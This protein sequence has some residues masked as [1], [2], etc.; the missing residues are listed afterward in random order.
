MTSP[1]A[2]FDPNS[3]STADSGIF[4][5][6]FG[7][8]DA[9]LVVIPVPWEVTTSY[10]SGASL[11]PP[12]ILAASRQVDLFDLDLV[13]PYA[14]GI[15]LRD[16]RSE[17]A[18]WNDEGKALAQHV[19]NVAGHVEGAPELEHAVTRVNELGDAL[20]LLVAE[21]TRSVL[22]AGKIP[23]VLGGDHSV[24]FGAISALAERESAFGILHIDA[25]SDTRDA[26]E[27]FVW[28]HASIM[29]NVLTRVPQVTRLVQVGIR[30]FCAQEHDFCRDQ[31]DRVKVFY[32]DQIARAKLGGE[33]FHSICAR[34]VESLPERVY[35][36]FDIDGLDPSLCPSTGTPVPGG[37]LFQEACFLL[38]HLVHSGR[39][40]IGFDVNEVAPGP[41][42]SEWDANVGARLLYKL[43]C[44][45]F[46]SQKL[47]KLRG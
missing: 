30:D 47:V 17:I 24:P 34:I 12:A 21:E 26:Y 5:L 29:R 13:R 7:E 28:S 6:P 20:N 16:A 22:A 1:L 31:S 27:G 18:T 35:I 15:F 3:A 38:R 19:I 40:V 46:A 23:A 11:A 44:W 41:P 42:G 33:H 39:T 14:P 10:G 43:A 32:D 8:T 37:L 9:R 25:H 2:D 45:T 4:G 36:S